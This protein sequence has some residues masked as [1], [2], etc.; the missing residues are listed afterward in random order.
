MRDHLTWCASPGTLQPD[1]RAAL[2]QA[3]DDGLA[4]LIK[5]DGD[6]MSHWRWGAEHKAVLQHQVYS[7]VPLLDRLSDLSLS[8][9]GGFYTLDRG[10]GSEASSDGAV[11]PAPGR[12]SRPFY[13][14]ANPAN[15]VR[16]R[17]RHLANLRAITATCSGCGTTSNR[18]RLQAR[19]STAKSCRR[20][21][22]EP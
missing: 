5:R 2:G 6:D 10:G 1:C 22:L 3:L 12:F 19:R 18:S 7:H 16:D 9:S 4:L 15:P 11:L 8:S 20:T 17:D 21:A 13:D 14:L